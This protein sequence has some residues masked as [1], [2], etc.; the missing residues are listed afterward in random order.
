MLLHYIHVYEGGTIR[1]WNVD[2][3]RHQ[4]YSPPPPPPSQIPR[5]GPAVDSHKIKYQYN[6][7]CYVR[8]C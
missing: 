8:L 7:K 2:A 1:T 3:F 6:M 5:Y 4:P